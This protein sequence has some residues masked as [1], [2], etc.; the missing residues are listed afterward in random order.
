MA[1]HGQRIER[2]EPLVLAQLVQTAAVLA[3]HVVAHLHLFVEF[4]AHLDDLFELFFVGVQQFVEIAVPD[5]DDFHRQIDRP[6]IRLRRG[7]EGEEQLHG[8]DFELL[9]MIGECV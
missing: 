7:A 5:E 4:D 8:R 1:R 2:A 3:D 6:G 9:G